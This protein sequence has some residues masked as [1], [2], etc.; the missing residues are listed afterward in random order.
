MNDK[1]DRS[2]S[3]P[4]KMRTKREGVDAQNPAGA[5]P[6]KERGEHEAFSSEPPDDPNAADPNARTDME[7]E[8]A[9]PGSH[10]GAGAPGR[11]PS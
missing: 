3:G 8:I 1:L 2:A 6:R 10:G 4:V 9:N 5:E 11:K 7:T